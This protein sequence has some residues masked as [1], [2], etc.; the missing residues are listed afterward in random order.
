MVFVDVDDTMIEVHSAK[1][2]GAGIGYTGA[3]GLNAL[4]ASASTAEAAPVIVGQRLR[5]GNT[6]SARGAD[7][8]ISDALATVNRMPGQ[9]A[10][11]VVRAGS[12]PN[13]VSGLA[14]KQQ[15]LRCRPLQR[16]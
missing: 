2:Q 7:K 8:Q 15:P 10:P 9:S 12:T 14:L 4:L 16:R 11:V 1:K 6:H 5:K 3:R 13:W